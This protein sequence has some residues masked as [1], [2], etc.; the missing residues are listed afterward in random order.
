MISTLND[1]REKIGGFAKVKEIVATA[2]EKGL[3]CDDFTSKE[4]N[5]IFKG[6][7][8]KPGIISLNT[9]KDIWFDKDKGY[10]R[11]GFSWRKRPKGTKPFVEKIN[12]ETKTLEKPIPITRV[13][14]IETETG[15]KIG[16]CSNHWGDNPIFIKIPTN[17][18][19]VKDFYKAQRFNLVSLEEVKE[20]LTEVKIYHYKMNTDFANLE[21]PSNLKKECKKVVDRARRKCEEQLKK[22]NRYTNLIE[23]S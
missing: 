14:I 20:D 9:A 18:K 21:V 23:N 5:A 7:K 19:I 2:K 1:V 13:A 17:T 3:N 6:N 15:E 11:G 22:V 16:Y 4:F 8:E 10:I 12:T